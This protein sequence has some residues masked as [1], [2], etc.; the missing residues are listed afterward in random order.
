MV[1][2]VV[3]NL[4]VGAAV[5]L[6]DA[7]F[8]GLGAE[9]GVL[10]SGQNHA[11]V[12]HGQTEDGDDLL[13]GVVVHEILLVDVQARSVFDARERDG[14]RTHVEASLQVVGVANH[15]Q[16]LVTPVVQAEEDA[17]AVVVDASLLGAVH[18][19]QAVVVVAFLGVGGMVFVV[20]FGAIGLLE[21]LIGADARLFH[22]AEAF[23]IQR[24]GVDVHAADAA[25]AFLGG[26]GHL[27]GVGDVLGRVFRRLAIDEDE[28][29][30][31]IIFESLHVADEFFIGQRG[32][33]LL[34]IRGAETT[35]NAVV[36][37]VVTHIQ[38][39]K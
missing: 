23:H 20:D 7:V 11:S 15:S 4:Q 27:H 16:H 32:A 35:V 28:A 31:A 6:R 37:A 21:N 24:S 18:R 8:D 33:D 5:D 14:V 3:A 22:D 30:L 25:L 17:E 10:T 12:R 39:G 2:F 19:G 34:L 13:E 26:V 36:H 38:G 29:L 1:V 9:G